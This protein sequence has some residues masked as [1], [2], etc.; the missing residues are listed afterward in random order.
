MYNLLEQLKSVILKKPYLI[1]SI[2]IIIIVIILFLSGTE[3]SA[4]PNF[5][6]PTKPQTTTHFNENVHTTSKVNDKVKQPE[7]IFVDIKGAVKYP[8]VYK[9]KS[10]DRIKQLLDKAHPTEQAELSTIN[11][12]EKLLDQKLV[13]IPNKNDKVNALINNR[14]SSPQLPNNSS[15]SPVNI[16]TATIEELKTINGIGESKAQAIINYREEHGSFDSIE[17]LKEVKGIGDKTFEKLQS[18][19][20]I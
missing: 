9:M 19:F 11:L 8:N 4:V 3:K 13:I 6:Q 1:V 2:S 12:A 18:E 14:M 10:S 15:K 7:T 16:N 5:Q 17:K 20:I